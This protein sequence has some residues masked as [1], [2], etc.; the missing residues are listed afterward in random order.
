MKKK[1]TNVRNN[2]PESTDCADILLSFV[3]VF[4]SETWDSQAGKPGMIKDKSFQMMGHPSW[5]RLIMHLDGCFCGLPKP[6]GVSSAD[7]GCSNL[8]GMGAAGLLL[9]HVGNGWCP[10]PG[11]VETSLPNCRLPSQLWNVVG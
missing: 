3:L 10:V 6:L 2:V 7:P 11:A 5:E 4:A 1:Q 8:G 9:F